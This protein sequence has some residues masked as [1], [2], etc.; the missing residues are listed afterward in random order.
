MASLVTALI[1]QV[2]NPE[3]APKKGSAM[4]KWVEDAMLIEQEL[5]ALWTIYLS[6]HKILSFQLSKKWESPALLLQSKGK[7]KVEDWFEEAK[8]TD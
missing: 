2:T 3:D 8:R 5:E 4:K 6:A 7:L 1:H